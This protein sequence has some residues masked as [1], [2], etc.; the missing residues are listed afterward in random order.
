MEEVCRSDILSSQPFHS[1]S[2]QWSHFWSE[3]FNA[4]DFHGRQSRSVR[5]GFLWLAEHIPNCE[6]IAKVNDGGEEATKLIKS[7]CVC[8]CVKTSKSR[9][10]K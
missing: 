3:L 4:H 10:K 9:F 5:A 7:V 1:A 2:L 6:F 8:V